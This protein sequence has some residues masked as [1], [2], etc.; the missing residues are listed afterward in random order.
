MLSRVDSLRAELSPVSEEALGLGEPYLD[1]LAAFAS[2]ASKTFGV[3]LG[4]GW[5]ESID[6]FS[7]LY[8]SLTTKA[9]TPVSIT[10][11]VK[12][13]NQILYEVFTFDLII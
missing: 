8:K 9:L 6:E 5:C 2:V 3:S 10:P 12:I 7:A 13:Q 4:E 1:T 11:K